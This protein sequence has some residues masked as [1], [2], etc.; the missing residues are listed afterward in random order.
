MSRKLILTSLVFFCCIITGWSQQLLSG[1]VSDEQG[2]P[3]PSAKIFVKNESDLRTL[4][5]DEGYYEMRLVEGEYFL[6]VTALGYEEREIYIAISE[7]NLVKD[8][9]LFPTSVKDV[10]GVDIKAKKSNP[11]R[12]IML[13]VVAKRDQMNQWNFPHTVEGYIRATEVIQRKDK[14]ESKK[15]KDEEPKSDPDGIIDPFEEERKKAEA[16]AQA[17]AS[18]MNLELLSEFNASR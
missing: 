9:T 14:K 3:I 4:V 1:T 12:E 2:V 6:I 8:I 18:N 11:G 13:K 10:E 16:A 5:N 15:G 17:V 7:E